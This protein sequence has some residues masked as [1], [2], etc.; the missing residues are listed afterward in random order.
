MGAT[1]L[2]PGQKNWSIFKV[3]LLAICSAQ[4]YSKYYYL[5]AEK[6]NMKTNHTPQKASSTKTLAISTTPV[7]SNYWKRHSI[8]ILRT[9]MFQEKP[10]KL[11]MPSAAWDV[12]QLKPQMK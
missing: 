10:T 4:E 5:N 8:L 3:K 9:S 1:G 6:V 12:I 7:L 11:Q 2:T